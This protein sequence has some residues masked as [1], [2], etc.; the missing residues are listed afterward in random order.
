MIETGGKLGGDGL[1]NKYNAVELGEK[2]Q[3]PQLMQL[4][5]RSG[6][7]EDLRHDQLPPEA[8]TRFAGRPAHR[9]G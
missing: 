2:M 1:G 3:Q 5:Q 9:N 7:G 4:L 8:L 6:V